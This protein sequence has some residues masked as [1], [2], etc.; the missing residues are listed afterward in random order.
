MDQQPLWVTRPALPPLADFLPAL[1]A[2]WSSRVLTNG[3]Q[4]H[5]AFEAALAE[6]LGV[7]AVSLVSNA[8][9]GLILALSHAA[10]G[11]RGQVLTSAFSFVATVHAIRWAGL[12]PV[13]ADIDPVTLNLDPVRAA[14]GM[15]PDVKAILP[16]HAFGTPC[17]TSALASLAA[18]AG[19]SLI[20][21]AAHAMGADFQG[22]SLASYGDM[23]VLSFHATKVLNTFEG[24]AIVSHD[25]STKKGLD[26][27]RNYGIVDEDRISTLGLNAK[28]SEFNAALGLLQLP[29]LPGLLRRR[30]QIAHQYQQALAPVVGIQ[31]LP[32]L[33]GHDSNH[34]YF[35]ILVNDEAALSRNALYEVLSAQG[36]RARKY[37]SPLLSNLPMYRELPSAAPANL[38]VANRVAAQVLCLPIYPDM[39]QADQERILHIVLG[40]LA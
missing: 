15:S 32:Q 10:G 5:Q 9:L 20:Y 18:E 30:A 4:F 19:V 7:A 25:A 17:Q 34:A 35:P 37:F 12:E 1:E 21:D 29:A 38:P 40:A 23:A 3:G 16:V 8:T 39:T 27:I 31:C 36:I 26:L 2:I 33:P 24:G 13:F 14:A 28:M 22:R 6:Y 11:A